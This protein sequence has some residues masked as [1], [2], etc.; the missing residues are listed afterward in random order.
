MDKQVSHK[1][2]TKIIQQTRQYDWLMEQEI[3]RDIHPFILDLLIDV[4]EQCSLFTEGCSAERQI[5]SF[6]H[7]ARKIIEDIK[8]VDNG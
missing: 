4:A 2:A 6:G 8:E 7:R 5:K 1:E 3:R